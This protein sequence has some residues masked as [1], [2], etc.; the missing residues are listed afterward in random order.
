M[1]SRRR[2]RRRNWFCEFVFFS[3][4]KKKNRDHHVNF[5][6]Y[7]RRSG[8]SRDSSSP[9]K[10]QIEILPHVRIGTDK[11]FRFVDFH[12]GVPPRNWHYLVIWPKNDAKQEKEK[13]KEKK[14]E[15]FRWIRLLFS[16]EKN[17]I[18]M[19]IIHFIR[20]DPCDFLAFQSDDLTIVRCGVRR[21]PSAYYVCLT[22]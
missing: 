22:V 16:L 3:H 20:E 18:T 17:V 11:I 2:R 21:R 14:K 19:R 9:Y 1:R 6:F 10:N 13:E 15:L 7:P 4:S 8:S 5:P 12:L